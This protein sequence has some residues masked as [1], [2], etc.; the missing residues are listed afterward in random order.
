MHGS[1][2]KS[3]VFK[4]ADLKTVDKLLCSKT[5]RYVRP[6]VVTTLVQKEE[7]YEENDAKKEE[8]DYVEDE[9]VHNIILK[10]QKGTVSR[11]FKN[12]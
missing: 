6:W 1:L 8:E 5:G 2:P 12:Y 10:F 4:N 9:L 7:D 11:S 3:F